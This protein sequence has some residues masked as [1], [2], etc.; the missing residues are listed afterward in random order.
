MVGGVRREAR[1]RRGHRRPGCS[2][3]PA[4]RR[5]RR[6]I[7]RRS[8]VPYSNLHSLTSPPS[9]FTVAFSVAVV[10]ATADAAFVTTVGAFGQRFE[11]LVCADVGP[12]RVR[13][14][15]PEVVGGVGFQS[16]GFQRRGHRDGARPGPRQRGARN[17]EGVDERFAD[18]EF[19]V[20][21]CPAV[22][23]HGRVQRRRGLG[24]RRR[25]LR[26]RP[27]GRWGAF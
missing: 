24:D 2:P 26:S 11:R 18:F 1:D 10:W 23:V 5:T 12:A 14:G 20:A 16:E 19:A 4:A 6:W 17:S 8:V 22:G 15:D 21:D 7:R 3:T 9:G 13:R 27:S 25:R